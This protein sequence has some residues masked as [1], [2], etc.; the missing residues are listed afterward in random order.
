M[1]ENWKGALI[2]AL[3][4]AKNNI[5]ATKS[6]VS[7]ALARSGGLEDRI[8]A[9]N[10]EADLHQRIIALS[11][12]VVILRADI[13]T[14][15]TALASTIGSLQ[16]VSDGHNAL[17]RDARNMFV[18]NDRDMILLNRTLQNQFGKEKWLVGV[19]EANTELTDEA[20]LQA[21][22]DEKNKKFIESKSKK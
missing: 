1:Q 14:I 17:V 7:G 5:K 21:Q 9:N 22:L 2:V 8:A 12:E 20:K 13:I 6:V 19:R 10:A 16:A 11:N 4:T 18:Q 15:K 3:V